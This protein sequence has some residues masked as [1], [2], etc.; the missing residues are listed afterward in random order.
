VQ[1]SQGH[2]HHHR[3]SIS[4]QVS[5]MSS[6][7]DNAVKAGTLTGDQATAMKSELADI[8][9]TLSQAQASASTAQTTSTSQSGL[10][11][12]SAT[13][14]QKVMKELH[15]VRKELFQATNSE[16]SNSTGGTQGTDQINSLFGA[17]DTNGDGSVSKTELSNYISQLANSNQSA[18]DLLIGSMY[19]PQGTL[20]LSSSS[21][22]GSSLNVF[23]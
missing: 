23:A 2:H 12:L 19:N 17:M 13:D 18:T 4:D 1:G 8:T 21:A 11:Q 16:A 6:A 7:I 9:N 10:S 5:D 14:R 22:Q 3:K 20:S 15:D